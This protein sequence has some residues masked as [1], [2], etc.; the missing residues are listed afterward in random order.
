MS[1]TY[2]QNNVHRTCAICGKPIVEHAWMVDLFRDDLT[3]TVEWADL[4]CIRKAVETWL[5]KKRSKQDVA[6]TT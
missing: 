2:Q 5:I 3:K 4:D 1:S 6:A